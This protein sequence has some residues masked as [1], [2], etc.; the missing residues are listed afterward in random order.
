MHTVEKRYNS[1][2][3]HL[4]QLF[5]CKVYKVTLDAGLNCPNRDGTLSSLGC[6]YCDEGGSFSRAQESA[7]PLKQQLEVGMSKLH[8]RFKAQKFIA[9]FQAYSNTY[10]P[11][12]K[13]K[14]LYDQ[15]S[16]YEDVVGLSIATRPDCISPEKIQ[17]IQ[18]YTSDYYVWLEYGLQSI[19][20]QSLRLINRGH[21]SDK[22][23]EAVNITRTYGPDINIGVHI[24]LGLPGETSKDIIE[25]AKVLSDLNIDGV[26]IHLLC[27]LEN[28]T[29]EKIY[30]NGDFIP[31]TQLE[32]VE[33][34]C[35]FLEH[36]SPTITIHRMAGNGL[37]KILVAPR[38]LSKKFEL[39]NQ[40]D[41]LLEARNTYQGCQYNKTYS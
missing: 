21:L 28:T 1:Y 6:I 14:D 33:A 37:K 36:L 2:S 20:D 24:I 8:N 31:L 18:T 34:V 25:T 4:K 39:L 41:S 11:V 5:G 13:L 26:K 12:D 16:G 40:I 17:L 23:Y 22:F 3:Q 7:W 19:N 15:I 32:Y 10:A 9:Y 30:L 27:V 38:W 29:L 35:N